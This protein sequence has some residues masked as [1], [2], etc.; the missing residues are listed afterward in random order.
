MNTVPGLLLFVDV[1]FLLEEGEL[2]GELGQSL[3]FLLELDFDKTKLLLQ[4]TNEIMQ[5]L[6]VTIAIG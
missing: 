3:D 1:E 5:M 2:V 4:L 6:A